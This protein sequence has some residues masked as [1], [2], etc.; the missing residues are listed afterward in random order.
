M[1][2]EVLKQANEAEHENLEINN[3]RFL[4]HVARL[5]APIVRG[6]NIV[7]SSSL[8]VNGVDAEKV[9]QK[10]LLRDFQPLKTKAFD[11]QSDKYKR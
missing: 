4:D 10:R 7:H 5:E 9:M 6:Q 11:F 8:P 1:R 2:C 3:N